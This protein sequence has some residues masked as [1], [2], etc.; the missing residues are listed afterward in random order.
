MVAHSHE[1]TENRYIIHFKM[2]NSV[3]CEFYLNFENQRFFLKIGFSS[4][5]SLNL[6]PFD[7][8]LPFLRSSGSA[9]P[10][11]WW[12]ISRLSGLAGRAPAT[13]TSRHWTDPAFLT[14]QCAHLIPMLHGLWSQRHPAIP[15]DGAA[16]NLVFLRGEVNWEM[17]LTDR[18]K[19]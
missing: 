14:L 7:A 5:Q 6:L 4:Q 18:I 11:T 13:A 17:L 3:G 16:K 2:M 9:W 19:K 12:V 1:C 8:F 10:R 15:T